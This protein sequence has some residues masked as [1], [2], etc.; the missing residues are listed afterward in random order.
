MKAVK[1]IS[2]KLTHY[3]QPTNNSCGQ[4][5][6]ATLLSGYNIDTT[7]ENLI[8]K[9]PVLTNEKGEPVGTITQQFATWCIGQGFSVTMYTFD[10]QIIDRSWS[11]L[12]PEEVIERMKLAL[13]KRNVPALGP[14]AQSYMRSYIDFLE[15]GGKLIIEPTVS[16]K[17]LYILL[18]NGPVLTCVSYSTL[19][20]TGRVSNGELRKST[21]DDI[22]GNLYNHTLVISGV[23]ESGAFFVMDPWRSAELIRI[24]PER[25]LC[26]ITAAQME[27]D[28]LLFQISSR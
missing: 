13:D 6:L 15:A 8:E 10:C 28:N 14:F 26:A 23:D 19:Y 1:P 9:L 5:A 21:P 11:T 7:P 16:S 2:H 20:G 27:C 4:A 22:D 12:K 17:L 24:E 25:L 3:F 18:E